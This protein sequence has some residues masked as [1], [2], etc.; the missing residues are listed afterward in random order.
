TNRGIEYFR[1]HVQ[2][3]SPSTILVA[4]LVATIAWI[5]WIVKCCS[6]FGSEIF[7][8]ILIFMYRFRIDK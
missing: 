8:T 7:D 3:D 4:I 1:R 2:H 5:R 6:W